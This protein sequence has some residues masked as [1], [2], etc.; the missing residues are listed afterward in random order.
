LQTVDYLGHS[1]SGSGVSMEKEKI[2]VVLEWPVPINIKQLRG[3]LG[4][5]GYYRRFIRGYASLA[6][7]L[8]NMLKKDNSQW[9]NEA[10]T[11]FDSLKAAMTQAPV[12]ALLDF[13]KPFTLE[14]DASGLGIRAVLS[15]DNH[16]IAFF[17][18]KL[19]PSL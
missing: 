12:L 16:P 7:P 6:T 19:T 2:K 1:I 18:K 4:L 15:Q 11:T 5:T 8:T 14:T 17:S 13:N 3:F 9:S 10:L